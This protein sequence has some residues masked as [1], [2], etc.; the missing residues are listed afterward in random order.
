MDP[1]TLRINV[2][3]NISHGIL[4]GLEKFSK[5]IQRKVNMYKTN[6][7]LSKNLWRAPRWS[8]HIFQHH[9]VGFVKIYI[10]WNGFGKPIE[11]IQNLML[12]HKNWCGFILFFYS[13]LIWSSALSMEKIQY[14][15]LNT[16][17][18]STDLHSKMFIWKFI[19]ND[20]WRYLLTGGL[21]KC[22]PLVYPPDLIKKV[23]H[24]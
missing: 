11:T 7:M 2:S 13:L 24:P 12:I 21:Q 20:L 5:T 16:I 1:E 17:V 14:E 6:W 18:P 23:I 9:P 3:F 22:F 15:H 19:S 10:P 8:P 4:D